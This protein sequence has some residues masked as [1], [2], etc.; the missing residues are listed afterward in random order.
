MH[1]C[2]RRVPSRVQ[3]Q[4]RQPDGRERELLQVSL[5]T[6]RQRWANVVQEHEIMP[7]RLPMLI[8]VG[9]ERV[10]KNPR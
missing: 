7:I 2:R 4:L 9:V 5:L 6:R 10:G 3:Q 8:A 1:K